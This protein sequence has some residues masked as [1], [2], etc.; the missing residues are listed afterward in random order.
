MFSSRK[1]ATAAAALTGGLAVLFAGA[2]P[3]HA[4]GKPDD[5]HRAA[6]SGV[7]CVQKSRTYVDK[8][9]TQTIKQEQNCSTTSRPHVAGLG[10]TLLKDEPANGGPVAKCSTEAELPTS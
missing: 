4:E 5:C 1:T 2:G 6:R 3:T 7:V 9:G 8:D 10:G